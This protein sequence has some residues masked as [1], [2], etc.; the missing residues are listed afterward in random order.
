VLEAELGR[1]LVTTFDACWDDGVAVDE[2]SRI[3]WDIER[4]GDA[5][6]LTVTHDG[7]AGETETYRKIS[8]GMPYILSGLKTLLETGRPLAVA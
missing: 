6:K 3:S 8:G 2:P 5:C 1:K 4:Q 7:F